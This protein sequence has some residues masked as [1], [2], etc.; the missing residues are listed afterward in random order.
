MKNAKR[1]FTTAK[2]QDRKMTKL[3]DHLRSLLLLICSTVWF[4]SN[5]FTFSFYE[6]VSEQ[7]WRRTDQEAR[8][9]RRESATCLFV[10]LFACLFVCLF[11]C[12]LVLL[13]ALCQVTP[14]RDT[15]SVYEVDST[16]QTPKSEGFQKVILIGWFTD[17]HVSLLLFP[18][19]FAGR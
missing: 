9:V 15:H 12:W 17:K 10:C 6:E 4:L 18:V 1:K 11:V 7:E 16:R 13:G 3:L 5:L 2:T 8:R 19:N 14:E